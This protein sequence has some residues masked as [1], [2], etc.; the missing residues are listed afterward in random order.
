MSSYLSIEQLAEKTSLKENYIRKCIEEFKE[1][2]LKPYLTKGLKNAWQ[3][4]SNAVVIFDRI[5][6]FKEQQ[7]SI[8]TIRKSLE[9]DL[10]KQEGSNR[11]IETGVNRHSNTEETETIKILITQLQEANKEAFK[12]KD[13]VSKTK[14]ELKE[15]EIILERQKNQLLLLTDGRSLEEIKLERKAQEKEQIEMQ[16]KRRLLL[17]ELFSLEGKWFKGKRKK[18]LISELEK[19]A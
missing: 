17:R 14:D 13:E 11:S 6:Y 15:K 12:A 2:I 10:S 16:E 3:L 7:Y 9:A 8:D 19:L 4:D 1:N 5:K 18:E